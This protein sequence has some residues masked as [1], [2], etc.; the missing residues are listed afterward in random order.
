M[1]ARG[2]PGMLAPMYHELVRG[3]RVCCAI[4]LVRC[5]QSASAVAVGSMT[6]RSWA[7]RCSMASQV[8]LV[9]RGVLDVDDVRGVAVV[10]LVIEA[11]QVVGLHALHANHDMCA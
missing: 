3:S 9:D 6:S 8:D 11:V 5:S 7:R 10:G 1:Q 4:S 2:L